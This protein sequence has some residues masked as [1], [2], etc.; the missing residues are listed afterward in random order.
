MPTKLKIEDVV[1]NPR[2]FPVP[3]HV[4]IPPSVISPPTLEPDAQIV[5]CV[6]SGL[7][8]IVKNINCTLSEHE[9]QAFRLKIKIVCTVVDFVNW[10]DHEEAELPEAAY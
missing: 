8:P 7:S 5:F 2:K 4:Q 6:T 1:K 3:A 9:L 10:A